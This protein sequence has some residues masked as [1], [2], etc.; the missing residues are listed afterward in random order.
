MQKDPDDEIPFKR[1]VG[2]GHD[3]SDSERKASSNEPNAAANESTA[4]GGL[5]A[6]GFS[7]DLL[8]K[9]P[10][11]MFT[12]ASAPMRHFALPCSDPAS[13]RQ[14]CS[15]FEL[16]DLVRLART[17]RKLHGILLAS[18]ARS[19]WSR[20][21]ERMGYILQTNMSE[22]QFA[23]FIAG[24]NCQVRR[25]RTMSKLGQQL[26]DALPQHC[27]T[28]RGAHRLK[29]FTWLLRLCGDCRNSQ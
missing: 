2:D 14:I 27:G 6:P 28:T 23:L 8:L 29:L 26:T 18:N 16:R 20:C 7:A 24:G 25:E 12:E 21:R 9:L 1:A 17:S 3:E 10:F 15:H 5:M 13:S 11:E 4:A 19:I 22:I